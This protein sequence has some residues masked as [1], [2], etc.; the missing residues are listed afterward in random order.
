MGYQTLN[1]DASMLNEQV[2]LQAHLDN[3]MFAMKGTLEQ[4]TAQIDLSGTVTIANPT[5]DQLIRVDPL[6]VDLP[7]PFYCKGSMQEPDCGPDTKKAM[8]IVG[9]LMKREGKRLLRDEAEKK[10]L[11]GLEDKIPDNLRESAKQLLNLFN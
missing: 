6:L 8:S 11:E 1:V 5:G 10:L 4:D 9:D 3:M 7:L 2:D